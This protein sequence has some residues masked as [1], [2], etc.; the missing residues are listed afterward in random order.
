MEKEKK[1]TKIGEEGKVNDRRNRKKRKI[2]E[3]RMKKWK[4]EEKILRY[5]E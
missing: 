1:N 4:K 2:A 3:E 5:K